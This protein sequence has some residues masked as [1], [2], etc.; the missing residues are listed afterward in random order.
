VSVR[1]RELERVAL[2]ARVM[3]TYY[4]DP[5]LGALL[6][7]IGDVIGALIGGYIVVVAVRRKLAPVVIAR[8]VMNIGLDMAVGAIPVLGDAADFAFKSNQMNAR[9]LTARASANVR[10]TW[11]DW[12]AVVGALAAVAGA[13]ALIVYV[14]FRVLRAIFGS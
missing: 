10:S 4:L 1:D 13:M 9:L 6:P 5:I 2:L 14:M 8:M 12:A 11:R 3:D 7:G